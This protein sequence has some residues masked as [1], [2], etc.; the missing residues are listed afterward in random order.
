MMKQVKD[1]NGHITLKNIWNGDVL[2][3]AKI[4]ANFKHLFVDGNVMFLEK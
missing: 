2:H 4:W 3:N 1:G